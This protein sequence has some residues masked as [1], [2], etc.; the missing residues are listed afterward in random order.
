MDPIF[1][2]ELDINMAGRVDCSQKTLGS[3]PFEGP[4]KRN[5]IGMG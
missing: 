3:N 4:R 2:I 5:T 1:R